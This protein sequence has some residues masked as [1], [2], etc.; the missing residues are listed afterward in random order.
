MGATMHLGHAARVVGVLIL[1]WGSAAHAA[2]VYW[3]GGTSADW[4]IGVPPAAS[5][6]ADG[7]GAASSPPADD[8]AAD[9]AGFNSVGYL[10]Q[11]GVPAPRSVGGISVESASDPVTI[12]GPGT[13]SIGG[14][15]TV[16]GPNGLTINAPIAGAGL[17]KTGAGTLTVSAV[18]TYTGGTN[19]DGGTLKVVRVAAPAATVSY[20]FESGSTVTNSGLAGAA[21]DGTLWGNATVTAAP[22]G[23]GGG[24]AMTLPSSGNGGAYIGSATTGYAV[25][26]GVYTASMWFYGLY[27]ASGFRSALKGNHGVDDSGMYILWARDDQDITVYAGGFQEPSPPYSMQPYRGQAAWHMLTFVGDGSSTTVYLDGAQAGGPI[28]WVFKEGTPFP[29]ICDIGGTALQPNRNFAN[30]IDDVSIFSQALTPTQV[31]QLYSPSSL[32][33]PSGT[34]VNLTASGAVLDLTEAVDQTIGSLAGVAGSSV[35][36]GANTLIAGDASST[37]FDGIISGAGGV[38]K[39]GAGT[40]T[41]GGANTHGGATAINAGAVQLAHADALQSSTV[42]V[43]VENGLTFAPGIGTFTVGGLAGRKAVALQDGGGGPVT[44]RVG[45]NNADTTFNGALSG[46]GGLTKVGSGILALSGTN[47]YGGPTKITSGTLQ[48]RS[49][50]A[51][52]YSFDDAGGTAVANSGSAGAPYTG[53]LWGDASLAPGAGHG[54]GSAM[55]LPAS[56]NGG[57]HIGDVAGYG[58]GSGVYTASLWFYGLYGPEGYRSAFKMSNADNDMYILSNDDNQIAYAWSGGFQTPTSPFSMKPYRGE[59][60]W[61]MLTFVG[62]GSSTAVYFDGAPA[63]N[64][65][66]WVFRSNLGDV[67]GHPTI[68]DRNFAQYI[69]DIS[70][71]NRALSAA[72]V[73]ALYSGPGGGAIPSTSP[74]TVASGA[75]LDVNNTTATIGPL[76]DDP[77]NGGG[78]VAL[79][80]G[81]LSVNNVDLSGNP[82]DSAFSGL[83]TGDGGSLVKQGPG[84]LTLGGANTHSGATSVNAGVV[85]LAHSGALQSST[86]TVNVDNGLKF[87]PGI[88]TF[89]L[90]GLAGPGAVA[91]QDSD[92]NPIALQA[93]NN[94]ASTTF[95]GALSGP[96]SLTK[97]GSGTLTLSGAVSGTVPSIT[98][99]AGKLAL[100]ADNVLSSPT[101]VELQGTTAAMDV[102]SYNNTVGGLKLTGGGTVAGAGALAIAG[103]VTATGDKGLIAADVAGSGIHEF[104]VGPASST[105]RLIV[106]G[107][108]GGGGIEKSGQGTLVLTGRNTYSGPTKITSG[109]LQLRGAPED[110]TAYYSFDRGVVGATV[111][112]A[113]NPGTFDGALQGGASIVAGDGPTGGKALRI[114]NNGTDVMSIGATPYVVGTGLPVSSMTGFTASAWFSGLYAPTF[115]NANANTLFKGSGPFGADPP[116]LM[117]SDTQLLAQDS[118]VGLY[119]GLVGENGPLLFSG[120]SMGSLVGASEWH[121]LTVVASGADGGTATYYLDGLPAGNPITGVDFE[122]DIGLVGNYTA[123]LQNQAFAEKLADVSIFSRTLSAAEVAALYDGARGVARSIP[124]DSFVTVA[125]GATLDINSTTAAIGP[126]GDDPVLG[127]G[128]VVLGSGRLTINSVDSSGNPVN[129][130][131]SGRIAGVGGSLVKTG[132]GTLTLGG[133]NTYTGGTSVDEGTLV[134]AEFGALPPGGSLSI[135]GSGPM[136]LASGANTAVVSP[137]ASAAVPEPGALTL[138]VVA[139]ASLLVPTARRR[140]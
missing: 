22:A 109:T 112:N 32:G 86:A 123:S 77:D 93:G 48:L 132:A 5:N 131:F 60:A 14:G 19:I 105:D 59:A 67:G 62:D 73:A 71:F 94:N 87:A 69:D 108:I 68:A 136:A 13:L 122:S 129:S 95:S 103:T 80:S 39:Q 15:V 88:A 51:V 119:K 89:T 121:M 23:H 85:R 43:N 126:L 29:S 18:C 41:L 58:V 116:A 124:S 117:W 133:S 7:A 37:R 138:L 11:P 64:A 84:M 100:G 118:N 28:P 66:P 90:G 114:G 17:A 79:G 128:M 12:S 54:G 27:D 81:C 104:H 40:M 45:N 74:V 140:R 115:H 61:H 97:I 96:G 139:A 50:L 78:T 46:A 53:T 107:A 1:A 9:I 134:V 99:Q 36:L 33:L 76:G 113:A 47:T 92:G 52:Y 120:F 65:I 25:G 72:E 57:I 16:A 2:T 20:T 24:N 8:A 30:Y 56:G 34:A 137:S 75:T 98:V 44:L 4:S 10:N 111:P 135:G 21:Y 125:D 35:T 38:T 102:G 63:G 110:A 31:Q 70:V 127:G 49:D 3:V 55:Q 101:M 106:S 6:W 91:L 42:S 82:V 83:I 130:S 26:S